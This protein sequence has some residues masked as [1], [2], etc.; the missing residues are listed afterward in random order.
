MTV[1][2]LLQRFGST[3]E[4]S[5]FRRQADSFFARL[6]DASYLPPTELFRPTRIASYPRYELVENV[7]RS[8]TRE[9]ILNTYN[10]Q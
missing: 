8:R 4:D 5:R 3:P 10:R 7:P 6:R 2:R 1:R 9:S